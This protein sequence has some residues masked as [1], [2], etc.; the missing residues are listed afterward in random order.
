MKKLTVHMRD[1]VTDS[2]ITVDGERVE[3][4]ESVQIT[5]QERSLD[6]R[7]Y[8]TVVGRVG[9]KDERSS[10]GAKG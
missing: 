1:R 4:V 7:V 8:F 3:G 5:A 10:A 2:Y 9:V 6:G